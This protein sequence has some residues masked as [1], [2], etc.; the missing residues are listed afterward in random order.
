M[1]QEGSDLLGAGGDDSNGSDG[2]FFEGVV[3]AG[4]PSDATDAAVQAN[5]IAAGY[6]RVAQTFPAAGTQYTITNVNSGKNVQPVSCGTANGTGIELDT[7]GATT[8]QQWTFTSAGNGH[9]VIT[10]A[11]SGTVLDSVNCGFLDGT[12]TDL[13]SS[14]DNL[15]QQWDIT[16]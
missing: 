12:L 6:Q 15:C 1:H 10:N 11:N 7:A 5:I 13:W 14:L 2:D 16:K 8:C 9:Y 4:Y 3:T